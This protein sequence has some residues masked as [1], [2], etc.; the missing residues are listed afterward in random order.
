MIKAVAGFTWIALALFGLISLYALFVGI[1]FGG[2]LWN[3][4]NFGPTWRW[5]G[6]V[7]APVPIAAALGRCRDSAPLLLLSI[8]TALVLLAP[9]VMAISTR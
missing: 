3:P 2:A 1:T 4:E 5:L 9:Y 6:V 7:L 8:V